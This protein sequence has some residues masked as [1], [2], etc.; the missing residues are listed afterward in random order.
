MI[1]HFATDLRKRFQISKEI[2][3]IADFRTLI[4]GIGKRRK[5]VRSAR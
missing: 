5:V 2:T 1:A 4:R 3:D